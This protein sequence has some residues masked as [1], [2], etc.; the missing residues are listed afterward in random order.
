MKHRETRGRRN[1]IMD[2]APEEHKESVPSE[3]RSLDRQDTDTYSDAAD[4][5]VKSTK[6]KHL[7]KKADVFSYSRVAIFGILFGILGVI[8]L[9]FSHAATPQ[10]VLSSWKNSD[11][12]V[13]Q[14]TTSQIQAMD[15]AL[16]DNP[17]LQAGISSQLKTIS[18]SRQAA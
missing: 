18:Q 16:R 17:Q 2:D 11:L 4:T 7:F 15:L 5:K 12:V 14:I 3:P 6:S 8:G 10:T 9:R 13:A 1:K